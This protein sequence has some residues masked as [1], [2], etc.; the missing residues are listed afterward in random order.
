MHT[1]MFL[2]SLLGDFVKGYTFLYKVIKD[3]LLLIDLL[4]TSLYYFYFV[5]FTLYFYIL[6]CS[7]SKKHYPVFTIHSFCWYTYLHSKQN[8]THLK[9]IGDASITLY[10]DISFE[11]SVY[12][13]WIAQICCRQ[14]LPKCVCAIGNGNWKFPWK[15]NNVRKHDS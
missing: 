15:L 8:L 1:S 2:L 6:Q 5:L 13:T 3:I 10:E 7:F 9:I 14:Q 4:L 12:L 11:P